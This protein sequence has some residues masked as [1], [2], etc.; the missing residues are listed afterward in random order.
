MI[1]EKEFQ[2]LRYPIGEFVLPKEIISDNIE[3]W[4]NTI[5]LFP[6]RIEELVK[7]LS[8]SDLNWQYRP[9]GWMI[10]QVVHH[11]ADS[12][13]NAFIRFKLCLTEDIPS[14]RHYFED[15]WAK[16]P[17]TTESPVSESL[18]IIKGLHARWV[19][20]LKSLNKDDLKKEL[21]HPEY[22]S[23]FSLDEYIGNY[24][25]HCDHHLAHIKNAINFK[26]SF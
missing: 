11:C 5:D 19:H 17:D 15:R 14:I 13:M 8:N 10:R 2:K 24:S 25:W 18:Q 6:K 16:L 22:K 21:F 4:I 12:H 3:A 9:E 7:E 20:L 23:Q 1:S 26:G